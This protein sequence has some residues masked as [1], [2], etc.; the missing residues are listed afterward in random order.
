M[1]LSPFGVERWLARYEFRVPY[2]IAESCAEP[3]SLAELA[4][5]ANLSGSPMS[6]ELRLAY[7]D[8]AGS[9]ELR[10]A[11]A[12]AYPGAAPDDVL[13][14]IGA[15][16]ANFLALAVLCGP[17]D[18][19]VVAVPAY[20]Q[21]HEVPRAQGADVAFWPLRR[22]DQWR[23]DFDHLRRLLQVRTKAVVVNF[24][25]NPTGVSLTPVELGHLTALCAEHGAVLHSDE[26]YRGLPALGRP[27]QPSAW[28]MGQTAVVGSLSKAYGLPGLRIGW[29]LAPA[30]IR[31]R[32]QEMRDYTSICPPAPSEALA[33]AAL[34]A[35][36]AIL[37]RQR[38]HA[39][40][41]RALVEQVLQASG[42]RLDWVPPEEGVVGCVR[43][44][45]NVPA[46]DFA[47]RL[48]EEY[49]TLV[50]P[51]DCFGLE[52]CCFRLGFGYQRERLAAGLERL[53]HCAASVS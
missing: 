52:G 34:R 40:A 27:E 25:N 41:N 43:L 18:R 5:L 13:V 37:E 6:S 10:S 49:G 15:I 29:L 32:A 31:E 51:G 47:T 39:A 7:V 50:V 23:P 42:G 28:G 53:L 48:A 3:L 2:N 35:R 4:E 17:G 19:V 1:E 20:Q 14:T 9:P 22:E 21:L 38:Q 26:V 44:R 46:R 24:P 33:M 30:G 45:A 16:E 12:A 36:P 11:I 8:A